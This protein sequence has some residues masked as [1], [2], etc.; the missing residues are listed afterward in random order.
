MKSMKAK[1]KDYLLNTVGKTNA[2][3]MYRNCID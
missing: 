1:I 3:Y 2:R